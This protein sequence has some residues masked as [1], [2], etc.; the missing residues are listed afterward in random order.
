MCSVC[1]NW[2][3]KYLNLSSICESSI[4]DRI[5]SE[6]PQIIIAS[7]EK[8]SDPIV[9]KQM[10]SVNLVYISLDEAQVQGKLFFIFYILGGL[11]LSS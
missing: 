2:K 7:I 9:Q 6:K 3:I 10:L 1:D 11:V 8:I 4:G 5:E